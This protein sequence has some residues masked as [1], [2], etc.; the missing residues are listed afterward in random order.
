M[1][2]TYTD[3]KGKA[4]A[5]AGMA[6]PHLKSAHA[7]LVR[8]Q[9]GAARQD[10][11]DAMAA[12]LAELDAERERE[13]G[14]DVVVPIREPGKPAPPTDNNPPE[15][16][17]FEAVKERIDDLLIEARNWCD[18]A[19]I[20]SQPQA[21][22]VSRLMAE[23]KKAQVAAD[24]ARKAENKPFDEGKAAVQEKYAPLIAD[25]KGRRGVTVIALDALKTTLSAWLRKVED[26]QRAAADAARQAAEA[27]AAKAADA[28]RA[29]QPDDLVS[30]EEAEHLVFG[31][32][33]AEAE[34]R[35][36]EQAKA[37]AHGGGRA[38]GLRSY[39]TP[40]LVDPK[41]ALL[42]YLATRPDDLKAFL[43]RLAE[44]DVAAGK[45]TIPGFEIEEERRVA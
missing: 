23:I 34:A 9:V 7:K 6:Y 43:V 28:V 40:R 26:Q 10:E 14:G 4:L 35:R 13:D 24:E 44:Q 19:A 37:H 41:A 30:R 3:S 45:R 8:E 5:V 16:T 36:A 1:T 27:A 11:I 12:R 18:G 22:E 32:G 38:V 31:A 20:E 25:T 17:T 42:H 2:T 33:Q 29:A 39:W 15:L 21:D